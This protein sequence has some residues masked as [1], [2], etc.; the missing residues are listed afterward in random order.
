[1]YYNMSIKN[2]ILSL[3]ANGNMS[4]VKYIIMII[5]ATLTAFDS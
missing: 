4:D 5:N 1:M 2:I 3:Y